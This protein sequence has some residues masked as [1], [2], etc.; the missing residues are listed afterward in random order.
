MSSNES[1]K[2]LNEELKILGTTVEEVEKEIKKVE[3]GDILPEE[4]ETKKPEEKK[5]E[6][7]KSEQQDK[8]PG[9]DKIE[10]I[11]DETKK[12]LKM[13]RIR[14]IIEN[15]KRL[16]EM[17]NKT[18]NL[19]ENHRPMIRRTLGENTEL[20]RRLSILEKKVN[21]LSEQVK[22]ARLSE[23]RVNRPMI[24]RRPIV[25]ESRFIRR[26]DRPVIRR[27]PI[28][29]ESRMVRRIDR[30]MIDRKPIREDKPNFSV[31]KLSESLLSKVRKSLME[32]KDEKV[33]NELRDIRKELLNENV[34]ISSVLKA[35]RKYRELVKSGSLK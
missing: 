9:V 16:R 32:C 18:G 25:S 30:P 22:R 19:R 24:H 27:R 15:R 17:R 10:D 23:S 34:S 26:T 20:M 28:L 21:I 13:E 1:K 8:L 35:N 2:I 31:N 12:E 14:R 29:S 6:D 33:L 11:P 3:S 7:V 4:D 5:P